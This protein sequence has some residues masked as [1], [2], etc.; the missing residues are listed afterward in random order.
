MPISIDHHLLAYLGFTGTIFDAVGGLYLSYDLLGGKQGPLSLFTRSVTYAI[1]FG[2]G[3]GIP[4]GI[5][6]GTVAGIGLGVILA[7]EQQRVARHQR[8]YGS[9]P[10]FNVPLFGVARGILFGVASLKAFGGEFGLV[11]GGLSAAALGGVYYLRFAP[12]YDY[13]SHTR[14]V[15]TFHR[16]MASVWRG[17]ALGIAGILAGW[18][19]TGQLLFENFGI[20][21]GLTAGIVSMTVGIFSPIVEWHVDNVPVRRLGTFGVGLILIG[22]LLQSAQYLPIILEIPLR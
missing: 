5:Y 20:R 13:R 8:L 12:T 17:V 7:F 14:P 10:L 11:F 6:F 22:L 4:F 21:I 15:I 19:V 18:I 2:L 1:F 9:S 3:Y 16:L